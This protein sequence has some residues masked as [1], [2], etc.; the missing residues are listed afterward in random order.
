MLA[1]TQF[2]PTDARRAFPCLDEPALK[3]NFTVSLA[4]EEHMATLSNME[5]EATE[6]RRSGRL[7][8][9]HYHT[10][11]KM[12][13]YLVAFVVSD[14]EFLSD[15]AGETNFSVW[16]RPEAMDQADY[17]LSVGVDC[18]TY[19]E[20]YFNIPYPLPKQ[21]MVALP[22][23]AAGA[24]E[25]WGETPSPLTPSS[26]SPP[27]P[28][29]GRPPTNALSPSLSPSPTSRETPCCT[30]PL[31]LSFPPRGDPTKHPSPHFSP[32]PPS[33]DAN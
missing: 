4:R 23:F 22:D 8:V 25:N 2:Q 31:F 24:M 10:T 16:A 13:T 5:I 30:S 11:V 14:F 3:A 26:F 9:D 21:D 17:S 20:S 12:S 29:P 15:L 7:G 28:L 1:A 6:P 33:G 32:S 27:S 18:L 19:F